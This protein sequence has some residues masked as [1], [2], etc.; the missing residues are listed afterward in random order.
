ML[1]INSIIPRGIWIPRSWH[2]LIWKEK[3]KSYSASS[4]TIILWFFVY[5]EVGNLVLYSQLVIHIKF[6]FSVLHYWRKENSRS[7]SVGKY[8]RRRGTIY[9]NCSLVI[10][11]VVLVANIFGSLAKTYVRLLNAIVQH[12]Y[13]RHSRCLYSSFGTEYRLLYIYILYVTHTN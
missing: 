7:I 1:S 13:I 4:S 10:L 2:G 3:Y 5:G 11:S 9:A 12:I 8:M 6:S